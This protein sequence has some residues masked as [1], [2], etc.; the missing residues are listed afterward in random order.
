MMPNN[1]LQWDDHGVAVLRRGLP[2][3]PRRSL[4]APECGR[5]ADGAELAR[6]SCPRGPVMRVPAPTRA[7]PEWLSSAALTISLTLT[8][9]RVPLF[10]A[11]ARD[12]L[13][14]VHEDH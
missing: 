5:W 10:H 14:T 7:A 1:A 13:W 9:H 12:G 2:R 6:A 3:S 4:G 11:I 8:W